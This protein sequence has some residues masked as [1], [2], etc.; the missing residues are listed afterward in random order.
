MKKRNTKVAASVS[1]AR[2]EAPSAEVVKRAQ[3][4][5]DGAWLTLIN[6]SIYNIS[7]P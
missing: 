7:L 5:V 1:P 6:E 2:K 4:I 3:G